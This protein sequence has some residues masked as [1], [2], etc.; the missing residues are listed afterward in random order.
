MLYYV[1]I[2]NMINSTESVEELIGLIFNNEATFPSVGQIYEL[3]LPENYIDL[4]K[5]IISK[6][7]MYVPLYDINSNQIFLIDKKNVYARIYFENYRFVDE[8]FYAD[9][10]SSDNKTDFD[11]NNIRILSF[12]DMRILNKTYMK[13]FYQSFV[14]DSYITNCRRPS[15]SSG[16]EHISPYYK[17]NELYYLAYDWNLTDSTTLTEKEI[18]HFCREIS[19]HDISGQTLLDHQMYIYNSKAIGL[20]KHYSLFGSYYM[21]VYLRKNKCCLN[22][23]N[24]SVSAASVDNIGTDN[25]DVNNIGTNN[26]GANNTSTDNNYEDVVQNTYL[27]NQ[28]N[29]MNKLIR[30]APAFTKS[31]TVYR[32]VQ[33]DDYMRHLKIGAVYKDSSFMSTTRNPFY[34][35]ENYA[36]GYILIKIKI[37][38]NVKGVG[39]CIESYSNFPLEEEII[40]PPTSMYRLDKIT[41]TT[42]LEVFQ[43]ILDQKVQK[44]YE[45]TWVGNDFVKSTITPTISMPNAYIPPIQ[46]INLTDLLNNENIQYLS[47]TDRLQYFK[48]EFVNINNQFVS[49]IGNN[50]YV[51][52]LEAYSSN[53][54]Y[55]PFFFYEVSDGIMITTSNPKYGNI[56]IIMELAPIIHI[57]YYFRFSV[58]DPSA[59]VDLNNIEWINWLSLLAYAVGSQKVVIHSN[60]MLKY[61]ES[62]T[63]EQKQMK[64]RYPFSQNIYMYLK[65][66]TKLYQFNS[67]VT[68]FDYGQLNYLFGVPV[69][70]IVKQ[71]D[72]NELYRIYQI[73]QTT[74][75]GDFY[76][77]IVENF[78]KFIKLVEQKMD[79]VFPDPDKNPFNNISY[80]IN[81]WWQ[82]YNQGL[83]KQIPS[84]KE[85]VIKKG[86]FKK[87]IGNKKIPKFKNRLRAYLMN[88]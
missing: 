54:V 47:M 52:N 49:I 21:N 64:T 17:I 66:K 9:L 15:F 13:I 73:S 61:D 83:I 56:N 19:K 86:S 71:S 45:F 68:D 60:Y 5:K 51:F 69:T 34:Y 74:N 38:E 7:D 10:I 62:D 37:P 20:V 65:H 25:A 1:D 57:N 44:K 14:L 79:I 59:V 3:N 46:E 28:I 11:K 42:D 63:I 85:F 50:K 78:P 39:L 48:T 30:N 55:K 77:Y 84:D 36:F 4:L 22:F 6:F 16:M 87:L 29:I 67:V 33:K 40:L 76:L 43:N 41:D 58:T 53:S 18:N 24:S 32:F 31:H 35:K 23:D 70:D 81:A 26:A 75:V 80:T 8:N 27:D 82:L 2:N 88:Q 12:Y 72:S